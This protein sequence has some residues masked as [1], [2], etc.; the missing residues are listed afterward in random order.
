M[1]F[2]FKGALGAATGI[3][4]GGLYSTSGGGLLQGGGLKGMINKGGVLGASNYVN[5]AMGGSTG[6]VVGNL[7]TG[8]KDDKDP[9]AGIDIYNNQVLNDASKA[10]AAK[11]QKYFGNTLD[12]LGSE[13]AEYRAG[14]K[15]NLGKNVAEADIYNQQ[16]GQARGLAETRAGLSGID[17]TALNE[18]ARRRFGIESAG[19]NESAK[20]EALDL[21][22]KSTAN[23]IE[24]SNK[25]DNNEKALA[26]ASMKAPQTNYNPGFLGSLFEGFTL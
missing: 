24:S 4:T 9:N 15:A 5:E 13:V 19:I 11:Q 10:S 6:S 17:N 3:A 14:L 18:G 23:L 12:N 16:Q 22:G 20:R 1:G 25:I 26:V 2:S 8:K 7:L 21:Y